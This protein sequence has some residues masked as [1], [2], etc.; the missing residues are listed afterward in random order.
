[1]KSPESESECLWAHSRLQFSSSLYMSPYT[2]RWKTCLVYRSQVLGRYE[3]LPMR[4]QRRT[5]QHW[6]KHERGARNGPGDRGTQFGPSKY[7]LLHFARSH[8]SPPEMEKLLARALTNLLFSLC[9]AFTDTL[10]RRSYSCISLHLQLYTEDL[11]E[12]F[13]LKDANVTLQ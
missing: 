6:R 4:A 2:S 7:I 5:A 13:N 9:V 1:M 11:G 8:T 3:W 12:D 10:K